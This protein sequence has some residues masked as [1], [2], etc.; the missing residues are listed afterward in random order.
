MS[1]PG[2]LVSIGLPVRN[3]GGRVADVVRSVLAQDHENLELVISDNAS[4]DDTADVCR[5]LAKSDGRIVYHRQ[6]RDI[7]LLNNFGYAIGAAKGTYFRWIGDDDRLEPGFVSRCLDVFEAD[8]RLILVTTGISYTGPDGHAQS[9]GYTGTALA[10]DDP[11]DRVV[12][13][14][15]LLNASHLLIDPLYGMVR[16]DRVAAIPRRNMLREDEVFAMK[17]AQ[18]G[19]WRHTPELLAHRVW[20]HER[21]STLGRRLGVPAWQWHFATTL[22][23]R[24]ML[25]WLRVVELSDDQRRRARSAVHRMYLTRQSTVVRRRARKL[26]QL[27]TAR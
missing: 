3:A 16:R 4:T 5:E 24:E 1:D 9:V 23:A 15:R 17:L 6:P 2:T 26:V 25:R 18:A 21:P 10:S 12:E 20:K 19:P 27:A 11:V 13:M 14:L 22:Q 8:R 7:G